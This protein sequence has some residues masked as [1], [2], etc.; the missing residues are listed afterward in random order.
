MAS[1]VSVV[2]VNKYDEHEDDF[3]TEFD[4]KAQRSTLRS[5]IN[6]D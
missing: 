4:H 2:T 3:N 1:F 5:N 6:A